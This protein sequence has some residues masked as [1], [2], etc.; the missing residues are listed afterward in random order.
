LDVV[1]KPLLNLSTPLC[2]SPV[3]GLEYLVFLRE[4]LMVVEMGFPG[5]DSM[6]QNLILN[7]MARLLGVN[8]LFLVL[9]A[10]LIRR[11]GDGPYSEDEVAI[12]GFPVRCP[13]R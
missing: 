4:I 1:E 6:P 13:R 3:L 11:F 2:S 7:E 10:S 5:E 8:L 9:R 12:L